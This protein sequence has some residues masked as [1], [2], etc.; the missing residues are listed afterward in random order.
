MSEINELATT[1]AS[2]DR[3]DPSANWRP[4][5]NFVI[6]PRVTRTL[7]WLLWTGLILLLTVPW[8]LQNHPHW[9]KVAWRPF[10]GIVRPV[11]LLLNF[12]LYVPFGA[13]VP[14]RRDRLLVV[15]LL[16]AI[17]SGGCE[18]SQVWSHWRFPS[19][20]DLVMNTLGAVAGRLW[21]KRAVT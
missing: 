8:D 19:T 1:P 21:R 4:D 14:I 11:D 5:H 10:V 7:G 16:A 9:Y 18:L 17:L 2:A 15:G 13:W 12:V 3:T 6:G 20:T